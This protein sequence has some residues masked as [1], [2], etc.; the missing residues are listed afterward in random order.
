MNSSP[1]TK[2][3]NIKKKH[4]QQRGYQDFQQWAQNPQ[5]VYIG[6]NMQFYVPGT[7]K[8]K[9]YNPFKVGKHGTL[10][11][12]LQKYEQHVRSKPELMEALPEL[13]G[14]ELGCWCKPNACHGDVLVKLL[15]ERKAHK[16]PKAP[17]KSVPKKRKESAWDRFRKDP[18]MKEKI[19]QLV[20]ELSQDPQYA[21]KS[22]LQLYNLARSILWRDPQ[23]KRRYQ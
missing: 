9:W 19:R 13:E 3:V 12:V 21:D 14:K 22:K 11:E 6:R 16:S 15:E 7:A 5:H 4:L 10:E 8:S 20:A 17:K 23:I 18:Y 2:V 1:T